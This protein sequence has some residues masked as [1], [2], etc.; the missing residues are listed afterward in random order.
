MKEYLNRF[1]TYCPLIKSF[2]NQ[3][4]SHRV[5]DD[6]EKELSATCTGIRD[7]C[8]DC[9]IVQIGDNNQGKK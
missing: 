4:V 3:E 1:V 5:K 6:G 9:F 8:K 2:V 7:S